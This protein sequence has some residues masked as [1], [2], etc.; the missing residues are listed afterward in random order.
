MGSSH[1]NIKRGC[2][3]ALLFTLFFVACKSD[4]DGS[5]FEFIGYQYLPLSI[6]QE[7]I[8]Q[9]DSIKYDDFTGTVDTIRFQRREL[10][11]DTFIDGEQRIAY[12]VDVFHRNNDTSDWR[13][14]KSTTKTRTPIRY[15]QFEDNLTTISLVFPI[16]ENKN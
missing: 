8:Y 9:V 15:E 1:V 4:D 10:V 6:G 7:S 5:I 13:R 2:F 16:S 3:I 11:V 12:Q 14:I